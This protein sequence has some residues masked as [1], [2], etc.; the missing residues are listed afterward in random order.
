MRIQ[1]LSPVEQ[2][3]RALAYSSRD[4]GAS[5]DLA[6][7]Y[8]IIS[9][10]DDDS[11]SELASKYDWTQDDL[12]LLKITHKRLLAMIEVPPKRRTD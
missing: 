4:W 7:I 8:G 10:W 6:W 9:G 12:I 2:L 5:V 1:D 3:Q 11:L